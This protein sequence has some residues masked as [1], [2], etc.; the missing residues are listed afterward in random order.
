MDDSHQERT[1]SYTRGCPVASGDAVGQLGQ[2][3]M[4]DPILALQSPNLHLKDEEE[5][6]EEGGGGRGGGGRRGGGR[7]G[8]REEKINERERSPKARSCGTVWKTYGFVARSRG[9]KAVV[10]RPRHAPNNAIMRFGLHL[11]QLIP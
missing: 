10:M 3:R 7:R 2:A 11:V 1:Q 5:A 4:L 6:E 8:R 9:K